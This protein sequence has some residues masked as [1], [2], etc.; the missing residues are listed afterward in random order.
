MNNLK[1]REESA[2]FSDSTRIKN[3]IMQDIGDDDIKRMIKGVIIK[4]YHELVN[5]KNIQDL[6]HSHGL[7]HNEPLIL[8]YEQMRDTGHFIAIQLRVKN[9]DL[10][11]EYFDPLGFPID[12]LLDFWHKKV[13]KYLSQLI[14]ASKLPVVANKIAPQS[15]EVNTCGRHCVTRLKHNDLT[16]PE[17][18]T[19]ILA[20]KPNPDYFVTAYTD[21]LEFHRK[22][23]IGGG[24]KRKKIKVSE[25]R[26][27]VL[28]PGYTVVY[29]GGALGPA[30]TRGKIEKPAGTKNMGSW[31]AAV[32]TPEQQARLGVNE[33]GEK[34]ASS[35]S[36]IMDH[37]N[38]E[39][40]LK[41]GALSMAK[42][43]WK[44]FKKTA[45]SKNRKPDIKHKEKIIEHEADVAGIEFMKKTFESANAVSK[46]IKNDKDPVKVV[47]KVLKPD[48]LI[49]IAGK[50]DAEILQLYKDVQADMVDLMASLN[51]VDEY[52]NKLRL[53]IKN[54]DVDSKELKASK[55]MLTEAV[56]RKKEIVEEQKWFYQKPE[57]RAAVGRAFLDLGYGAG[58]LFK[59]TASGILRL[60]EKASEKTL[61][62]VGQQGQAYVTAQVE[63][64]KGIM[65]GVAGVGSVA[66]LFMGGTITAPVAAAGVGIYGLQAA[67]SYYA[68]TKPFESNI[69]SGVANLFTGSNN[70]DNTNKG[71]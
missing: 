38:R 21:R 33:R 62:I 46:G 41:G 52:I 25:R 71:E 67:I 30:W 12:A 26:E 22:K 32:Y 34:T 37:L 31:T 43:N 54:S 5:Y 14:N 55:E 17:Y 57:T 61:D 8:L 2:Y 28:P 53:I 47:E 36:N 15:R 49:F 23:M 29:K 24:G 65:A 50:S 63:T 11:L 70:A 6:F 4:P 64:G 44:K 42:K 60:T 56:R 35:N 20:Q 51:E 1:K 66:A 39:A 69:F 13:P 7:S 68:G 40:K 10:Y 18:L 9:K 27:I 59:E 48:E 16:L 19:F 45:L 3:L 58:V